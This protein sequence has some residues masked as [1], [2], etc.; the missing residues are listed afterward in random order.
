MS[1]RLLLAALLA[2]A[3]AVQAQDYPAKSIRI[4]VPYPAGGSADLLPR[5]FSEK[6]SA[7]WGQPVL[8]E[9]RP[10]AG[11]NIG[12]EFV[13]RADP[14]GYT[15]FASAPGP[16]VVNQN[17]YRNL[18]FDPSQFVPVSIMAAIPNVLLVNPALPARSV[19]GLI[20]YAKANPG[21]LNYGSQGSGSTSHL[22]AELFKTAAGGLKITHVP[23]KGS[24]PAMTALLGGEIELM[25]DNLGI[26]L[27]HIR[28]GKLRILAVGSEKRVASL[29]EVPAMSEILPGFVSVA[30]FGIVAP[31]RTPAQ[32]ADRF[33]SAVAEAIRQPEVLSRL[34]TLSAEPVGG[35][36]SEMAAFMKQEE[37]RWKGVIQAAQVK[38]D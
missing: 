18:A 14:D 29:P 9:N 35:T 13:Y 12:A 26:T 1:L 24:A 36:P 19:D 4:V 38:A 22:T 27:P 34:A 11:G 8:V 25:F 33:S 6:L 28:T 23:Y 37:A 30:W 31:P 10:G 3:S 2:S 20:A 16:L 21:K 32:V 7:K 5:I 15:L 17:L